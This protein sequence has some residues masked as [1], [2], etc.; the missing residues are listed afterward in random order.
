MERRE[1]RAVNVMAGDV[2]LIA[3]RAA[4]I[5]EARHRW[6]YGN[7]VVRLIY[8]AADGKMETLD[9]DPE[10]RFGIITIAQH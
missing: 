3:D 8:R 5:I 2:L 6:P 4:E 10:R 1:I 7:Q 9:C